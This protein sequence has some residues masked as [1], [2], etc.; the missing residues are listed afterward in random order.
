MDFSEDVKKQ[1]E[2]EFTRSL[3]SN[4]AEDKSFAYFEIGLD[5]NEEKKFDKAAYAFKRSMELGSKNDIFTSHLLAEAYASWG[6]FIEAIRVAKDI[7]SNYTEKREKRTEY[8]IRSETGF[9]LLLSESNPYHHLAVSYDEQGKHDLAEKFY[10]KGISKS[11]FDHFQYQQLARM[12]Q[13]R[14]ESNRAR[15]ILRQY[16]ALDFHDWRRDEIENNLRE[17]S[18]IKTI[19]VTW[20]RSYRW[21]E[22]KGEE[23][24]KLS[25]GLDWS[26]WQRQLEDKVGRDNTQYKALEVKRAALADLF[27]NDSRSNEGTIAAIRDYQGVLKLFPEEYLLP[28]FEL[29]VCHAELKEHDKAIEIFQRI[30]STYKEFSSLQVSYFIE[31]N[32]DYLY[33]DQEN[34]YQL[35]GSCY[36]QLGDAGEAEKYYEEAIKRSDE[37]SLYE[38]LA[39][40][41]VKSGRVQ[42]ALGTLSHALM[43]LEKRY[44][45]DQVKG[46]SR[47]NRFKRA[48]IYAYRGWVHYLS[49]FFDAAIEDCTK[50]IELK[51]FID[52]LYGT[53]G[54]AFYSKGEVEKAI[55]DFT[56]AID[57]WEEGSAGYL[58]NQGF[59]FF[60]S[61]EYQNAIESWAKAK[62]MEPSWGK[63]LDP[64]IKKAFDI[65]GQSQ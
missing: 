25:P 42:E 65:V 60:S 8:A 21:I 54:S 45:Y 4:K 40:I 29:G 51:P 63:T 5:A 1:V 19:T 18:E 43:L 36:F 59:L 32:S 44:E 41:H 56:V 37:A 38:E 34:P 6:K 50:A 39:R 33:L 61:R 28:Y 57:Q 31:S 7:I 3:E 35:L 14:R 13:T 55:A 53:R 48:D 9:S 17:L 15:D 12:Y 49:G 16:L 24:S 2:E 62:E 47:L 26:I 11:P 46:T 58:Y 22:Y 10:L 27:K 20:N 23:E 30:I 64:W 52:K